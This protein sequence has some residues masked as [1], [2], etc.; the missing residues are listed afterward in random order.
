MVQVDIAGSEQV[1][2]QQYLVEGFGKRRRVKQ[3]RAD[4]AIDAG[5]VEIRQAC[6]VLI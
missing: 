3:L 6:G 2:E 4:M 5:N 1:N